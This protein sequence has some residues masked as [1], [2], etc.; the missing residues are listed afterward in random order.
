VGKLHL[1]SVITPRRE[2]KRHIYAV[3]NPHVVTLLEQILDHVAPDGTLAPTRSP[4]PSSVC[5][6]NAAGDVQITVEQCLPG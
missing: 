1:A 3:D 2:G 4:P 5:D 6:F